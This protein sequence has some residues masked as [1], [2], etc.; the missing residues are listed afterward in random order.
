[1]TWARAELRTGERWHWLLDLTWGDRVFYF[2]EDDVAATIGSDTIP[3]HAG[4]DLGGELVDEVGLFHDAAE[5]RS[6]NVT[7]DFPPGVDV[8]A[9]VARGLD[10]G[11]ATATLSL[12]LEG[13]TRVLKVLDGEF[14]DPEFETANDPVT[15][16]I[17]ELPLNDR[18]LWPPQRAIVNATTWPNASEAALGEYYPWILGTPTLA[19]TNGVFSSPGLHV[20]GGGATDHILI[21]GHAVKATSVPVKNATDGTAGDMTVLHKAD[22]HGRQVAYVDLNEAGPTITADPDHEYWLRFED[23]TGGGLATR[24]GATTMRG[25]GDHLLWWLQRSTL[26]WDRGRVEALAPRL[27]G[28]KIDSACTAAPDARVSPWA[29]IQ[30]HLLDDVLPVAPRIGPSGLYFAWF[31]FDACAGQA[32]AQID[33]SRGTVRAGPLSYTSRDDVANEFRVSYRVDAKRDKPTKTAVLTGSQRTL[34]LDSA[35]VPH[36][37]CRQSD[38]RYG[39]R[40][41]ELSSSVIY[42]DA[43][44]TRVLLWLASAFALQHRVVTYQLPLEFAHLEPG[45][46]V[47]VT[48][49]DVGLSSAVGLVQSIPWQP[50]GFIEATIILLARPV[51]WAT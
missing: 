8:P 30:E 10:L 6:V 41:R 35:A 31:E 5:P 11:A 20:D 22:G 28:F 4:L 44:A 25:A 34:D 9:R 29:W 12:W 7:L 47:T 26:R 45:D 33:A 14:R 51:E 43:T 50:S 42:D 1:M 17:E 16:A 3:Y 27:N 21:A 13:T 38:A 18:A 32:I 36:I 40:V 46:V 15:G 23:A 37:L 49:S 48:D 19:T 39:T 2:S 24:D